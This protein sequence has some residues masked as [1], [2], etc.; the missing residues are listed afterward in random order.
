MEKIGIK[1]MLDVI[2]VGNAITDVIGSCDE[3][4]LIEN[5]I[6]KGGM[7]LVDENRAN[8]LF[9]KLDNKIIEA[10][11]SAANSS[12]GL[13][14]LGGKSAFIGQLFD[15]DLGNKFI[16]ELNKNNIKFLGKKLNNGPISGKSIICVTPDSIR[17]MNTYLGTSLLLDDNYLN[18]NEKSKFV[19]LEGYLF[20]APKSDKIFK[21]ATKSAL[22]NNSKISLSL[23]DSWCVERHFNK[24]K[25]FVEQNVSILFCNEDELKAFTKTNIDDALSYITNYVDEIAV[26]LGEKGAI[27][28]S[29]KTK[30]NISPY[31]T[32]NI[33]D[34]TG[35]GDLFASGYLYGRTNNYSIKDSGNLGSYCAGQIIS[36]Y[37]TKPKTNLRFFFK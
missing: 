31:K 17:S 34:T 3:N 7:N 35:A 9:S 22:K 26:T 36:H 23:S 21:N 14:N 29:K 24:I 18:F 6:Q 13:A 25:K 19:Y 15:D 32:S 37:G 12:F 10:G 4:F 27:I 16:R 2:F 8:Y 5:N 33:V 11:G 28:A 1:I 20:D 30:V